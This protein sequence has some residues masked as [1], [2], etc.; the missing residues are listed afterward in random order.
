MAIAGSFRRLRVLKSLP[1]CLDQLCQPLVTLGNFKAGPGLQI[2]LGQ[3]CGS[4][5]PCLSA[6]PINSRVPTFWHAL[7]FLQP[8]GRFDVL[9]RMTNDEARARVARYR[10]LAWQVTDDQTREALLRLAAEYEA[11]IESTS[12]PVGTDG[13]PHSGERSPDVEAGSAKSTKNS[14]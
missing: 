13:R 11:L 7:L 3:E 9:G 4:L 12:G 14:P 8:D 6:L 1:V 2:V 5:P 10:Q